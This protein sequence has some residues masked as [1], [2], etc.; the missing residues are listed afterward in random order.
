[1]YVS[2][3]SEEVLFYLIYFLWKISHY[4][5]NK[6]SELSSHFLYFPKCPKFSLF[7]MIRGHRGETFSLFLMYALGPNHFSDLG[8]GLRN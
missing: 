5:Q 2:Q 4:K 8:R 3:N 6:N 7:L 1:M